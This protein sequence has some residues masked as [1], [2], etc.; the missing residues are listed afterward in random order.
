MPATKNAKKDKDRPKKEKARRDDEE[1]DDDDD[2]EE[3]EEEEEVESASAVAKRERGRRSF[4]KLVRGLLSFIPLAI[5]LSKEPFVVRPRVSGTNALKVRPLELALAGAVHWACVSPTVLRNPALAGYV[6]ST[7]RVLLTPAEYLAQQQKKTAL[8]KDKTMQGAYR[9]ADGRFRRLID[10]EPQVL[11][12]I[13]RPQPN[14][15]AIGSYLITA[16]ALLCPLISSYM[17]YLIIGG[18]IAVMHGGRELNMQPMPE[19]YVTAG[20]AAVALFAMEMAGKTS[21]PKKK[22]RR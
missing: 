3:E 15:L 18:S 14:F 11:E 7:A 17:E 8:D 12:M 4:M 10:K 20:V 2:D 9:K 5:V 22:K 6:N 19:L 21:T 1:Q 16:G 13:S